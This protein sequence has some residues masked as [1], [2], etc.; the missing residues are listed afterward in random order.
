MDRCDWIRLGQLAV[1]EGLLCVSGSVK[2]AAVEMIQHPTCVYNLETHGE[3]VYRI[4]KS[5]VL[6]HNTYPVHQVAPR[7]ADNAIEQGLTIRDAQ[8]PWRGLHE[9]EGHHPIMRGAAF[10][11]F[12]RD[13]GFSDAEIDDWVVDLATDIHRAITES[14]WWDSKLLSQIAE[15][16]S[17]IGRLGKDNIVALAQ[18]VLG[19][20]S[21]WSS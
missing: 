9:I 21:R 5:G 12:W 3:H 15:P 18:Q 6:V 2:V 16:E 11:Q 17:T 4:G 10:R 19:E 1:G 13:R 7:T 20:M 8:W 14:G